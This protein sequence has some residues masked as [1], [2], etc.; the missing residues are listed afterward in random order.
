MEE[1]NQIHR[2]HSSNPL[3]ATSI[4]PVFHPNTTWPS[5]QGLEEAR[6][7]FKEVTPCCYLIIELLM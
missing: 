4:F 5:L 3:N 2:L 6:T 1:E 7:I